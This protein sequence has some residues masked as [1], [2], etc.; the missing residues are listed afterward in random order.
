M[1]SELA[2]L[3]RPSI[4][5][6]L[7]RSGSRGDQIRNAEVFRSNGAAEVLSEEG[8]TGDRLATLVRKLLADPGLLRM[9]GSRA[10]SLSRGNP[11]AAI[12]DLIVS[13][14]SAVGAGQR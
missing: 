13:R 3:G 14:I 1:L 2:A 6:P 4:L 5:I 8:A 9:M 12:A 11:A 7:P 10:L